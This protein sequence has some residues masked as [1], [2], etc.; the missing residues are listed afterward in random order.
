M[1]GKEEAQLE[2]ALSIVSGRHQDPSHDEIEALY[3][4]EVSSR[5]RPSWLAVKHQA[6]LVVARFIK[7]ALEAKGGKEA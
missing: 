3:G 5:W 1:T 7:R 6:E 4:E 2:L